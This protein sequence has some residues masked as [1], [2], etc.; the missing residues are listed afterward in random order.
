MKK[1]ILLTLAVF[2]GAS[3]AH[4]EGR[5]GIGLRAG[6]SFFPQG[7]FPEDVEEQVGPVVSGNVLYLLNTWFAF[8]IN[9]EWEMHNFQVGS[10]DVSDNWT[11]SIIP[12]VELRGP[13]S[14]YLSVGVGYNLNE[15]DVDGPD[16]IEMDDSVAFKG[17]AGW[18]IFVTD[19]LALN[20]E[21]GW[22]YNKGD[23]YLKR[24]DGPKTF[25]DELNLSVM[26]ALFGVRYY[27]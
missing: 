15:F 20:L 12:F 10:T 5:F 26:S 1:I 17:A 21:L 7:V 16:N 22:K 2:L 3:A 14:S 13:Y 9:A 8:G 18:D 11:V 27:F 24:S 4:A 6:P 23:A 25:F 19:N